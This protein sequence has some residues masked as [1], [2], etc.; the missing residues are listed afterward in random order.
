MSV[1]L[2]TAT[3]RLYRPAA[4]FGGRFRHECHAG[5]GNVMVVPDPETPGAPD[6]LE[7][8]QIWACAKCFA[9]H[10]YV[11]AYTPGVRNAAVRLLIG[12]DRRESGEPT[13]GEFV[14]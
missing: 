4:V 5:C 7:E 12:V 14:P 3:R 2:E 8:G 1:L 13:V 10:E 6:R 11:M 9:K